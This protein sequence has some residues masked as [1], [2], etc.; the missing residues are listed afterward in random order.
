MHAMQLHNMFDALDK[1][2]DVAEKKWIQKVIECRL[3]QL[4]KVVDSIKHERL[5]MRTQDL[6]YLLTVLDKVVI[7]MRAECFNAHHQADGILHAQRIINLQ[8]KID[9]LL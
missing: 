1:Q 8:E 4:E 9:Q 7:R 3:V 2:S 5:R 6:E